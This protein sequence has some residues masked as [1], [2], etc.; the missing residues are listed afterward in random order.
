VSE[1]H[2]RVLVVDD[3]ESVCL[4]AI[5]ALGAEGY[6]VL[7]AHNG[8]AALKMIREHKADAVV[9]DLGLPEMSGL[10]VLTTVREFSDLPILIL[11]GRADEG[12]RIQGLR[13]GADDY[14]TKPCSPREI[15]ARVGTVLRRARPA[16]QTAAL[17]FDGLSIDIAAHELMIDGH[18]VALTPMEFELLVCLARSPHVAISRAQLLESVWAS[19][20]EWQTSATVTE[21]VRRLRAKIEIAPDDPQWVVTVRGVGYRFEP[22]NGSGPPP[23]E[24][25]G[26]TEI[27]FR[28]RTS[29]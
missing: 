23:A 15:A 22:H 3:D 29:V 20:E 25:A 26:A 10:D 2:P 11:S 1:L 14:M 5:E 13:L 6:R 24:A 19:S 8:S 12:D 27:V 7:E 17:D 28:Q 21:H 16:E 9:L 4:L 18:E